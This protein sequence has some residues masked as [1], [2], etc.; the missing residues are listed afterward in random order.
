MS[1]KI[2]RSINRGKYCFIVSPIGEKGTDKYK[3]FKDVYDYI[4][5]PAMKNSGYDFEIVRADDIERPG[6]FIKDILENLLNSF[7][8]IADLSGQNPNVFYELGVRHA[9]SP[10]T[11]LIAQS[12]DD[13]PSDLREYRTII[14]DD[15]AKG[16]KD[17]TDKLTNY[18]KEIFKEPGRPD[19]PVIDRLG[20]IIENKTYSLEA[21]IADLKSKLTTVLQKGTSKKSPSTEESISI[22]MARIY[23]LNNAREQVYASRGGSVVFDKGN[24]EKTI[25]LQKEQGDFGLYF[26][27]SEAGTISNY[28]YVSEQNIVKIEKEIADIRVLIDSCLD[29]LNIEFKFI[30][31]TNQ[32]LSHEQERIKKTFSKMLEFIPKKHR[33]RFTL[34]IWD[35]NAILEQE[36]KLGLKIEI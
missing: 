8:I 21:E 30:I 6:S 29:K 27:I 17:F 4:I 2:Q 5:K 10:R 14:Y 24:K 34:E 25:Y 33:K 23:K 9:L 26:L 7:V 31:A 12:I 32:D 36:R 11:I 1:T 15:S 22:R 3:R 28:W 20:S 13:I 16:V 35:K 19:N 18:F